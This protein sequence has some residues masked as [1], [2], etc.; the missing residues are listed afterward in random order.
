MAA[1]R[2]EG[3]DKAPS[4]ELISALFAVTKI[5]DEEIIYRRVLPGLTRKDGAKIRPTSTAFSD[6]FQQPSVDRASH[7]AHLGGPQWTQE[8]DDNGVFQFRAAAGR[9]RRDKY[10]ANTTEVE[11]QFTTDVVHQPVKD[12]PSERDNPAHSQIHVLPECSKEFFRKITIQL[13]GMDGDFSILPK[14]MRG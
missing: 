6:R 12:Q 5:A 1:D 14:D 7:C 10:K 13:A 3:I 2:E 9:I 8:K 11:Q 4:G